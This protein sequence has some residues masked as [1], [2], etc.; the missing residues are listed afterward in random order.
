MVCLLTA[1]TIAASAQRAQTPPSVTVRSIAHE[2]LPRGDRFTIEMTGEV[3]IKADRVANPDRVFFDFPNS[4]AASGFAAQAR[5]LQ[6]A[7]VKTV[8]VGSP[9]SGVTRVV[10]EV[11]GSPRYSVFT[12]YNPHRLVI[13]FESAAPPVASPPPAAVTSPPA[14]S[15]TPPPTPTPTTPPVATPTPAATP[16]PVPTATSTPTPTPKPPP[17]P[18]PISPSSTR[19]GDYSLSRQLGLRVAK[20]VID[21][22][23]GGHDPGATANGVTEAE[24]VLDIALRL[25]AL[26]EQVPGLEVVLTRRTNE[27]V[28]LEERT[29]IANREG[30]DLFLSIHANSHRQPAIRGIETYYLN[31]ASNPDAEAVAARENAASVQTVSALPA[32]VKAITLNDKLDESRELAAIIQSGLVRKVRTQAN[33]TRDLGVKQAPF[34]VLI[35]AQMPSVLT[36]I[37]FLTNKAEAGNMKLPAQRQVVAQ[38]LRDAILKYQNSLKR[39]QP[40]TRPAR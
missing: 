7:L 6:A 3:A 19:Q 24:L 39:V 13:D 4:T 20:V 14:S 1:L 28:P 21:P 25:Q 36:E 38:A 26:L 33:P 22:G 2:K 18:T 34:V 9:S 8:R 29:A 15:S 10:F 35:G 37:A 40:A 11:S 23:H 16:T 32:I 5:A 27:F 31:F 12:L 30:A 17:G